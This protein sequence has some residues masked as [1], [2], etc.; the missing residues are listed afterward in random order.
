MTLL[1]I[2]VIIGIAI[3]LCKGTEWKSN[4]RTPPPGYHKD[5]GK[6]ST[7]IV[8]HGKDYYHRQN[9]AGKYDVPD[10]LKKK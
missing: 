10:E 2:I 9:L 8:L 3:W 6:S 7:D 1:G 5:W 4:N